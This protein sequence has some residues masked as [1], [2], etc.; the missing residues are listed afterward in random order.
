MLKVIEI[1]TL[2]NYLKK[3][4]NCMGRQAAAAYVA[5]QACKG[6]KTVF[7]HNVSV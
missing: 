5:I 1:F 3:V 6:F 7:I 4:F 2:N